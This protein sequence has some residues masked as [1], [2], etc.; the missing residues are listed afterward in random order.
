[1]HKNVYRYIDSNLQNSVATQLE[2]SVELNWRV[3]LSLKR[4]HAFLTLLSWIVVE[5]NKYNI[6]VAFISVNIIF[7][8]LEV[9]KW[10]I[11]YTKYCFIY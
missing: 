1:M 5:K 9:N 6:N 10:T 8:R 11:V 4:I 3:Y 7:S 2:Q